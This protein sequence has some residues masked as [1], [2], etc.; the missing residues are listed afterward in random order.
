M[1]LITLTR[2]SSGELVSQY[3]SLFG[4]S[5]ASVECLNG[6]GLAVTMV[7]EKDSFWA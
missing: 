2:I 5:D 3:S 4:L 6:L 7:Q 1:F